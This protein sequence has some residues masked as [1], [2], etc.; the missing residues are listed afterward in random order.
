MDARKNLTN[1]P[2]PAVSFFSEI[3]GET[4]DCL[5]SCLVWGPKKR[6]RKGGGECRRRACLEPERVTK[7]SVSLPLHGFCHFVCWGISSLFV[8]YGAFFSKISEESILRFSLKHNSVITHRNARS[9]ASSYRLLIGFLRARETRGMRKMRHTSRDR[10]GG[11]KFPTSIHLS[12]QTHV[13][14]YLEFLVSSNVAALFSSS[15]SPPPPRPPRP[16]PH[17]TARDS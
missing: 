9:S 11:E 12:T 15:P 7:T 13:H 17:V 1:V 2:C 8:Q 14:R 16:P 4:F 5:S 3:G 6:R 10:K